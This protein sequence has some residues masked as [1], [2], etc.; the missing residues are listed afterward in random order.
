M[1]KLLATTLAILFLV[2]PAL[3]ATL[4]PGVS[5]SGNITA[6]S[7]ACTVNGSCVDTNI[8]DAAV[9][10]I[11]VSGTFVGVNL[12]FEASVAGNTWVDIG[13]IKQGQSNAP[14]QYVTAINAPAIVFAM[15]GGYKL[16]R[17]RASTYTSGTVVV[18]MYGTSSFFSL[19]AG[20]QGSGL[21][22]NGTQVI[23]SIISQWLVR[24]TLGINILTATQTSGANAAQTLT[25]TGISGQRVCVGG[26]VL[27]SSAAGTATLVLRSAT[28]TTQAINYGTIVTGTAPS[29]FNIGALPYC[30]VT[31]E[32]VEVVVG[33][34]GAAVTTTVSANADRQ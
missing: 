18:Q 20:A 25:L 29:Q 12:S 26:I 5:V 23:G 7:A 3:A 19:G 11:N 1:K 10:G 9:V 33:A 8:T 15:T 24:P 6:A 13:V 21:Q 27:F 28:T 32:S 14:L 2:S 34:A 22:T 16:F 30:G 17:V 4:N 31:G